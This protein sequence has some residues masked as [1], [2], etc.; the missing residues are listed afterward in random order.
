MLYAK[1]LLDLQK[2]DWLLLLKW[3]ITVLAPQQ[4]RA[5]LETAAASKKDQPRTP[6]TATADLQQQAHLLRRRRELG[7]A[8]AAL[9]RAPVKN[10][11][12]MPLA[13]NETLLADAGGL[14]PR[15]LN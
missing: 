1:F 4:R 8:R 9:V 15:S 11:A 2:E 7:R 13:S 5:A 10:H 6:A 12:A 3:V 14:G